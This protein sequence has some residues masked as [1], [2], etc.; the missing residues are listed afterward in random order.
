MITH[1]IHMPFS[2]SY[3]ASF[4]SESGCKCS[5]KTLIKQKIL[6]IV[7]TS[8]VCRRP[9]GVSGCV[10]GSFQQQSVKN[11]KHCVLYRRKHALSS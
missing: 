8:P 10:L 5:L 4:I 11:N 6:L 1:N 2:G 7:R 3:A 9:T